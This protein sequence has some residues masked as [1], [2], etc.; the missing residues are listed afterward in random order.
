MD[1]QQGKVVVT[2]GSKQA[3]SMS[4]GTRDHILV[5]CCINAN[6]E[7]IPPMIIF[8]KCF[9]STAYVKEGIR[10]ILCTKSTNGY[11][12]EELFFKWFAD[13]FIPLTNQLG[14]QILFIDGHGSHLLLKV[15]DAAKENNIIL[16]CLPSHTT[17]SPTIECLSV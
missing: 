4:N 13:H 1:I 10:D 17:C 7:C 16:Y 9:P 14:K 8:E 5:N 12:D 3:H 11:M 6:G 15:I 2:M